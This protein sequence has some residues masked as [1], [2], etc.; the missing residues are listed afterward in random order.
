MRDRKGVGLGQRGGGE[1]LGGVEG[2]KTMVNIVYEKI[3]SIKNF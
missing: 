2:G 3:F 1:G